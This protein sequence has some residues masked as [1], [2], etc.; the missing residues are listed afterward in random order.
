M[1]SNL[2]LYGNTVA[3]LFGLSALALERAAAWRGMARRVA[4]VGALILSVALPTL[5]LLAP[6]SSA[7][8]QL[9][10]TVRSIPESD[11][12]RVIPAPTARRADAVVSVAMTESGG[13]RQL[14]WPTQTSLERIVRPL[15]LLVSLG[16]VTFYALLWLRLR[17]AA[18][19]WRREW[20]DGQEVWVTET[21]GPA[22]YGLIRPIIL[23]P[24]WALNG[25][26]AARAVIL[27]HEQEHVSAHD[28]RLLLLG[29]LLVAIA[30]WNLPLWWQLR[31]LRFAIEVDCDARVLGRGT[32][33][34]AYGEVLLTIGQRRSLTPIGAIA[35]TEPASQLLRRIRIMTTYLPKRSAWFIGMTMAMALAFV[36]VAAELPPP[37]LNASSGPAAASPES[38]LKPP[39]G[40]DPRAAQVKTLVR[41]T[42]PELFSASAAPAPVAITMVLNADGT[43]HKSFKETIEPKP[44]VANS[45][46]AFQAMGIDFEHRGAGVTLRL[47]GSPT[48]KNYI[49]VRAWYL[50]PP[51]DPT[52]DIARV[53][54]KIQERYQSLYGPLPGGELNLNNI[55][56]IYLTEAGDIER[57]RV[58]SGKGIYPQTLATLEHFVAMGIP[59]DQI[60]PIGVSMLVEGQDASDDAKGLQV[61]YAWPRRANEPA[62]IPGHPESEEPAAPNDNPAVNRAIAE[63]YFPDLYTYPKTWPRADPWVLLDRQGRVLKTGRRII[64][65]SSDLKLYLESLYPGLKTN[66]FQATTV[67]G[68]HAQWADVAFT[69]LADYSPIGDPSAADPRERSDLF[70]FAQVSGSSWSCAAT[71]LIVLK[72]DSPEVAKCTGR[73]PFGVVYV[74]VTAASDGPDAARLRISVQHAALGPAGEIPDISET[75][76]SS[77]TAPVRVRYGESAELQVRDQEQQTWKIVLHPDRLKGEQI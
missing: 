7:P 15:W 12:N 11:Q 5:R 6:Q 40:E 34:R 31:R 14:T 10:S 19:H 36:A 50:S 8:S 21:L 43:L 13:Q 60:G 71:N 74:Q 9:V 52:R 57:A 29:M 24:R 58:D 33:A 65:S 17:V 41:S 49:D 66:D 38:L 70:F 37:A 68:D 56:S 46:R 76:W 61:I 23:M 64:D 51:S 35:L 28:P 47:Q 45:L 4:W 55:L 26:D 53:R 44:Y 18:R 63:R 25:P 30:P 69:W 48:T 20:I 72:Y 42:Y 77:Q 2:V 67:H 16:L 62:P 27:A 3:L 39:L 59:R 54:A 22:V 73:N 75:A 32:E 1:I